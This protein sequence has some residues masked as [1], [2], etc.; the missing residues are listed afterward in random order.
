MRVLRTVAE[1]VASMVE[2]TDAYRVENSADLLV[3]CLVE[4]MELNLVDEKAS[5]MAAL[6]AGVK[7]GWL[8]YLMA[9]QKAVMTAEEMDDY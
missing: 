6:W 3:V 4:K 5:T 2:T 9:S 8:E 7:V 1:L